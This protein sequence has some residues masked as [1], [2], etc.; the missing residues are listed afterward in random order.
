MKIELSCELYRKASDIML[1]AIEI[2]NK[3][4]FAYRDETFCILAVNAWELLIK[5]K[6]LADNGERLEVLYVPQ[7]KSSSKFKTS[8]S[9]P[10]ITIELLRAISVLNASSKTVPLAVEK[11]LEG[12]VQVRDNAIHLLNPSSSL[13]QH[14]YELCAACVRNFLELSSR[15]FDQTWQDR[16]L[17]LLP[18]GFP[19]FTEI[20]ASL[21][22]SPLGNLDEYLGRL[23]ESEKADED[24]DVSLKV[25]LS[26]IKSTGSAGSDALVRV[27]NNL[28]APEVRMSREQRREVYQLTHK[29]LC[30]KLREKCVG[31]VQ[32][33]SF[34]QVVK[35]LRNDL[36]YALRE[37]LD[38]SNPSSSSQCFYNPNIVPEIANRL[39][40][41]VKK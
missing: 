41:S 17:Y 24:F 31:F 38:P 36:R 27:T 25:R 37:P 21:V 39:K 40:L 10:P 28:S 7:S 35:E 23:F 8:R 4:T 34:N 2:Y 18:L 11:N 15:W 29:Q 32:N 26:F 33:E 19:K 12:L 30:D 16:P 5:A 13:G 1:C 3:P 9:G 6:V 20:D 22:G 14:I